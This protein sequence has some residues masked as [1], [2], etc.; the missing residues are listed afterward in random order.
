MI[1]PNQNN[2]LPG[3]GIEVNYIVATEILHS[4][5]IK[6]GAKGFFA[7]KNDLEKAYGSLE[8][9]F[10]LKALCH[11]SFDEGTRQLIMSCVSSTSSSVMFNVNESAYHV[12]RDCIRA[13]EVWNSLD[14]PQWDDGLQFKEWI[15]RSQSF[16]PLTTG[17]T[18]GQLFLPS[19]ARLYGR[20]ET[21]GEFISEGRVKSIQCLQREAVQ[22]AH[23]MAHQAG[24]VPG[25]NDVLW[26][27]A[28]S[29]FSDCGHTKVRTTSSSS[30]S[31]L[32]GHPSCRKVD[33]VAMWFINGVTSAFFASL[34]R[35]SCIRVTTVEDDG[36][37]I[38]EMPLIFNDG[39]TR[40][41][42]KEKD[43]SIRRRRIRGKKGGDYTNNE[44]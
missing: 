5:R 28:A 32:L 43:S 42:G 29:P 33:G 27:L 35:C 7:I 12:L 36:E 11:H 25:S 16:I 38:N 9:D 22:Q 3:R 31:S 19:P 20:E 30:S 24:L 1:S 6:K 44:D 4:M 21:P 14:H 37:D 40:H 23:L 17:H 2:F 26:N 39:N 10:I 41:E 15:S 34:E 13:L 8:W 18:H